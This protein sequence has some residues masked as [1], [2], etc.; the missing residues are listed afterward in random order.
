MK[1]KRVQQVEKDM[2]HE[3]EDELAGW[4]RTTWLPYTSRTP[5]NKREEFIKMIVKRYVE[6]FPPDKKGMI[7]LSMIRLEAEAIKDN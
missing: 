3:G 7:H 1:L 2:I 5:E 6:K 4:I